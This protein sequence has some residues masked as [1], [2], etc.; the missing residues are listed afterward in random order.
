[1]LKKKDTEMKLNDK[2]IYEP[3]QKEEILN[4]IKRK[5][6]AEENRRIIRENRRKI[7]PICY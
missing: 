3:E 1:M 2:K 6:I 4:R 7:V 5:K